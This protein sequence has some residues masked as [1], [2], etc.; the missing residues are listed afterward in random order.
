MDCIYSRINSTFLEDSNRLGITV[1]SLHP[2]QVENVGS[3]MLGVDSA[4]KQ[5]INVKSVLLS[6]QKNY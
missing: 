1:V 2:Y 6:I 5:Q 3:D 4:G